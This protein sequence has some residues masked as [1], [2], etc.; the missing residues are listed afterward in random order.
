MRRLA[1]KLLSSCHVALLNGLC[2]E[3]LQES[4]ANLGGASFFILA[5]AVWGVWKEQPQ[6]LKLEYYPHKIFRDLEAAELCRQCPHTGEERRRSAL[7]TPRQ[8]ASWSSSSSTQ[9]CLGSRCAWGH[10]AHSQT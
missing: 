9:G 4:V 6:F 2:T 10:W 7:P 5:F 1:K 3:E 8:R